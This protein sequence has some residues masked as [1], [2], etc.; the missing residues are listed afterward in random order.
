M[1]SSIPD[2]TDGLR[3]RGL[4]RRFGRRWALARVSFSLAPGESLMLLGPNGSGKTTLLRCL[5][6]A[7]RPHEGEIV[8]DG[9]NAWS[10]RSQ[11]RSSIAMLSHATCLYDDLSARQN[12]AMWASMGRY[13]API[14][15][16]LERVGLPTN[17]P[18]PVR[19]YSAGMRR[20]LSLARML[21]KQPRLV[22]LD[23]PF[24][25]LDPQGRQVVRAIFQEL[26]DAGASLVL[27]THLPEDARPLCENALYLEAGRVSWHRPVSEG[28]A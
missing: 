9:R 25:S 7:L 12:L 5:A 18:E 28:L 22:L 14:D 17:R 2:T 27:A 4:A 23:E 10:H 24:S 13:D 15:P 26:R 1:Q 6:T 19:T 3:V 8:L 16:L 21:L 20:R 11:L